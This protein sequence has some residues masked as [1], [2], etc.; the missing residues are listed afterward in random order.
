M[1]KATKRTP[2]PLPMPK[3]APVLVVEDD[4]ALRESLRMLLEL[5][6][7]GCVTVAEAATMPD[8]F[9]YLRAATCPHVVL[10]DFLLPDANADTL[11]CLVRRYTALQRH[12][13]IL[14]PASEVSRFSD[15]AQQLINAICTEVITKPFDL[16]AL[17]EAVRRGEAQLAAGTGT[18]TPNVEHS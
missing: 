12:C 9:T 5:E 8:A 1:P 14:M 10:L 6:Y 16:T 15:E 13:Y 17:L 4:E 2:T 11:L 18:G 3:H 7:D